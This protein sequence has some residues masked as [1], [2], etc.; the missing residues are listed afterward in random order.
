MSPKAHTVVSKSPLAS[1][2]P[3]NSMGR[4]AY[5]TT[6]PAA[7]K[8]TVAMEAI[9]QHNV[10][11]AQEAVSHRLP[12]HYPITH[13]NKTLRVL[14][15]LPRPLRTTT[16]WCGPRKAVV[17]WPPGKPPRKK[18]LAPRRQRLLKHLRRTPTSPRASLT[19]QPNPELYALVPQMR[20]QTDPRGTHGRCLGCLAV[21]VT[22]P[23]MVLKIRRLRP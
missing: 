11:T 18:P 15:R 17:S 21:V 7:G 2:P 9:R 22:I 16:S 1:T 5:D 3:V 12:P 8:S 20:V 14:P 19:R 23:R 6:N 13:T 4:G 10:Q